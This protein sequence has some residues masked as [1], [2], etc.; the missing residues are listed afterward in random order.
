M[1]DPLPA[2]RALVKFTEPLAK[3]L[4]LGTLP[5]HGH[6]VL[7]AFSIYEFVNRVISPLISARL[8]PK[9]YPQLS[10]KTKI[11]WNV[12][13]VSMV[14]SCFINSAA[15][16]VIFADAERGRM[17]A[18]QR[19]WGYTGAS[20]MVQGF[21]AGYFLWDLITSIEDVD[22]HG[23]GALIHAASA[24]A[25]TCLGFRPFV[26]YYGVNLILYELSTPFLNI[27]WF[28]DKTGLTGSRAQLINGIM[29]LATFGGSR[30][31]WGSYQSVMMYRDI[32]AAYTQPGELPVPAWLAVAKM[33]TAVQKRFQKPESNA[34]KKDK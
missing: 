10:R 9:S 1:R 27:H 18:M 23:W 20:G 12:H 21:S 3:T 22:V 25:V 33:I 32:W 14:Q 2:P 31:V 13:F 28:M 4:Y 15:L 16:W 6:E 11:N 34:E 5:S 17:G 29:L 30:L 24:L 26:N 8:F 19:V 7:L